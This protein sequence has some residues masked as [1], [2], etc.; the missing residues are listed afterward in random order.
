MTGDGRL[1]EAWR[2]V[3]AEGER[4]RRVHLRTLLTDDP[5]RFRRFHRC[6]ADRLLVDVAKQRI[7]GRAWA[8][9]RELARAADTEAAIAR[10]FAGAHVNVTEDRAALHMALRARPED[11]FTVDGEDATAAVWAVRRRM[12]AFVEGVRTGVIRG[13]TGAHFTDVVHLGIGG[14][15]LGPR[16]VYRA[17]A[18]LGGDGPVV[19]FVSNVDP[20]ALAA[21]LEGLD[22]A[23]TLVV[24][25]SKTFTTQETMANARAARA[26][27]VARLGEAAVAD[28]FLAVSTATARVRAFG[29]PEARSFGFAEWVGGRFSLWGPVG[30][31]IALRYG[32]AV[33]G[34]LLEG[35]RAMDRHVRGT[36]VE[37][38]LAVWLALVE[39]WNRNVLGCTSRVVVP[40]DASLAELVLHL[41]Q[42]EMESNG[43]SVTVEGRPVTRATVPVVWGSPGTDGQHAYFQMLHQGT[44]LVPV[45]FLVAAESR[46]GDGERHRMLVAHALAQAEA[47]AFGREEAEV[48]AEME[49]AGADPAE[50]ARL[51]PHRRMAGNR[52]STTILVRRWDPWTLGTLL[53]LYEH[54]VFV[55]GQLWRTCSFDQFGVELGKRLAARLV[56]ELVEG[57]VEGAH[58]SS[59]EGLLR[60]VR[61]WRGENGETVGRGDADPR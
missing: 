37:D 53:A 61:A 50:I 28:H 19:H 8:A 1:E 52:P 16:A 44:D 60:T 15:E 40:Y 35:A 11:R 32:T 57:P 13:H 20:Q 29:I 21:V 5:G 49:R 48:V 9:L 17:L 24:V 25:V 51:A 38:N 18:P 31:P 23:R 22:P 59:T 30:I 6:F 27:L 14:S 58:D 34:E 45:E 47:L 10:L 55:L 36:P 7:D 42:L 43:K 54:K 46:C 12:E 2:R 4:L 26:W 33:Y 3:E 41:Q 39:V 56:E